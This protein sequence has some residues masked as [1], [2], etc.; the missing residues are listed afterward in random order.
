MGRRKK[1]WELYYDPSLLRKPLD[2]GSGCLYCG[3]EG[4]TSADCAH[5]LKERLWETRRHL[6]VAAGLLE[7]AMRRIDVLE[8]EDKDRD[9]GK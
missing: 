6:W 1:R 5:L 8:R 2:E 9:R 3:V 7:A 4:H